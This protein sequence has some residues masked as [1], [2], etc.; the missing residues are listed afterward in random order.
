MT[1]PMKPSTLVIALTMAAAPA[2]VRAQAADAAYEKVAKAWA[3]TKTLDANFE[4]KITKASI[5][6]L[7]STVASVE[8]KTVASVKAEVYDELMERRA[9]VTGTT[10]I[11]MPASVKKEKKPK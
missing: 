9:I 1:I 4:Q 10:P 11:V 7:C 2:L 6:E 8:R 3:A 5:D